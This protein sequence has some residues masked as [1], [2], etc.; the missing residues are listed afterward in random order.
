MAW[1]KGEK[2]GWGGGGGG[3]GWGGGWEGG[4]VWRSCE[5]LWGVWGWF[6]VGGVW[7]SECE[8]GGVVLEG[9]RGFVLVS[10]WGWGVEGERGGGG[11]WWFGWWLRGGGVDGGGGWW[12]GVVGLGW[13]GRVWCIAVL[14]FVRGN[15]R[16]RG[17][18]KGKL[19]KEINNAV[20]GGRKKCWGNWEDYQ[21]SQIQKKQ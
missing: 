6:G 20:K 21:A 5:G 2:R 9:W 15:C 13:G 19:W 12:G 8:R 4:G 11:V 16:I 7:G 14:S 17:I 10:F 3:V 18:A 1:G